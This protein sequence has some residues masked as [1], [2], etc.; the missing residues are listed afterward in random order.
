MS[1]IQ[2]ELLIS[3]QKLT[4]AFDKLFQ[5]KNELF[6]CSPFISPNF[7]TD[8]IDFAKRNVKVKV[9]TSQYNKDFYRS[10]LWLLE[11]FQ[12]TPNFESKIIERLHAKFYISDNDFAIHGS[13]NLTDAGLKSNIEQISILEG[14]NEINELKKIFDDIWKNGIEKKI[15]LKPKSQ[16][17]TFKKKPNYQKIEAQKKYPNAY[18][19]WTV[20][21]DEF[22]KKFW[23]DKSNKQSRN[24]KI[25]ELMQKFGRNRGA[26]VS[27]LN[28]M[29]FDLDDDLKTKTNYYDL[30]KSK[31]ENVI[32]AAMNY[33]LEKYTECSTKNE[34]L[35][36]TKEMLRGY[37]H[38]GE[39]RIENY[40]KIALSGLK[41]R[42]DF[43]LDK[44]YPR[45]ERI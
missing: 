8:L 15:D 9:I 43:D 39:E 3:S 19:R 10:T 5:A 28:K 25:Q 13:A 27:R 1:I 12:N 26:I 24:E 38:L 44:K 22:L 35:F 20:Y 30:S 40:L 29:G 23:S 11:K 34:L 42:K 4:S 16:G 18:E 31:K 6:I 45:L 41:V 33:L 36:K 7:I 37:H 17:S 14:K 2:L 21:D 32:I